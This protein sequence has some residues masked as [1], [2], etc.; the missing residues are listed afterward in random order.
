MI[1]I[2]KENAKKWLQILFKIN[3]SRVNSNCDN[4]DRDNQKTKKYFLTFSKTAKRVPEV[5]FTLFK[6][7]NTLKS[8]GEFKFTL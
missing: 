8:H 6:G 3:G 5:G 1:E 7:L 2:A 4:H